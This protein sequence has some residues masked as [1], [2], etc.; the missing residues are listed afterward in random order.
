MFL[1]ISFPRTTLLGNQLLSH[2]VNFLLLDL[3]QV[4]LHF[5]SLLAVGGQE[6]GQD[7]VS[8]LLQD[9]IHLAMRAAY[10]RQ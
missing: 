9:V 3:D 6:T 8:F 7:V 1:K 5:R 2:Y 4:G 10:V